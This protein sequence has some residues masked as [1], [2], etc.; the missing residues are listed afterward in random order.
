VPGLF[1]LKP[2]R[3]SLAFHPQA[4]G[5]NDGCGI[6]GG[7]AVRVFYPDVRGRS[8]CAENPE[9]GAEMKSSNIWNLILAVALMISVI[10]ASFAFIIL[11]QRIAHV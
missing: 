4:A 2:V 1:L 11:L 9:D 8:N 7:P 6:R 5:A 3:G 10:C